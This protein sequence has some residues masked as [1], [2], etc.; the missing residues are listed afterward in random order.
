MVE[1]EVG[2]AR[3]C[4]REV[5]GDMWVVIG[6]GTVAARARSGDMEAGLACVAIG[7]ARGEDFDVWVTVA[8]GFDVW[9]ISLLN[10]M[11][12]YY[13]RVIAVVLHGVGGLFFNSW[14]FF[15]GFNGGVSRDRER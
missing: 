3:G 8:V 7:F 15:K 13:S 2:C 6:A 9:V 10:G 4:E 1:V 12:G 11:V 14:L 5:F